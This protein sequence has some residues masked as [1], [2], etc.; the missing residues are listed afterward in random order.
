[1]ANIEDAIAAYV[2]AR[3]RPSGTLCE[4]AHCDTQSM[5]HFTHFVS[6]R[7][8][9]ETY[10]CEQHARS[11]FTETRSKP[12]VRTHS[13]S[14]TFDGVYLEPEIMVYD[15]R[16][17]ETPACI[18]LREDGGMRRIWMFVDGSAWWALIEQI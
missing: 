4:V 15:Q 1:M 8:I 5:F 16:R 17:G 6:R 12:W 2:E 9:L 18:C 13:K 14:V 3:N 7:V 11:F 10:F